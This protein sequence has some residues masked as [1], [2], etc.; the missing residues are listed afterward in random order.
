MEIDAQSAQRPSENHLH[1]QQNSSSGHHSESPMN[2]DY[3]HS[4]RSGAVPSTSTAVSSASDNGSNSSYGLVDDSRALDRSINANERFVNI[5]DQIDARVEKLR[6]DALNLQEMKDYLLMSMD[7]IKSN[8]KLQKM[9]ESEREEIMLYIQRVSSRLGTVELNV[10]TVRDNSQEDS[11][12]QINSLIDTMIKMGD[13]VIGRQRCQLYLNACCS[14][15]MDPSGHLDTLSEA[16][17]GPIDKKFESA[18]LGCT[19]DDQKNIK[20]RLQ[21]LMGYLNKQTVSH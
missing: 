7:L 2:F 14:S 1:Q 21:A 4:L 15:A 19:L 17:V 20:K 18:L 6:K 9:R 11:L 13:P 3:L 10:R 8:D 16:D 5:L 12:S